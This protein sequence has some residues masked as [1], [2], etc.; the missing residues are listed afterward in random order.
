MNQIQ[1][2]NKPLLTAIGNHELMD[3]GRGNYYDMFGRFYYSFTVGENY[4]IVLDDAD[5]K[6]KKEMVDLE[7]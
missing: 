3:E 7:L 4:F 6:N 2:L 1:A 5:S